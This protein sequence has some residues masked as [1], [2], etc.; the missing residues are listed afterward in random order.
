MHLRT[1]NLPQQMIEKDMAL[2]IAKEHLLQ[3][4]RDEQGSAFLNLL[5]KECSLYGL[6]VKLES[7]HPIEK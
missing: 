5:S 1:R 6:F 3:K 2:L 4:L 7:L